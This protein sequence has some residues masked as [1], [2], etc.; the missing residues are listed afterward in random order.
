MTTIKLF[1]TAILFAVASVLSYSQ[2]LPSPKSDGVTI[3][4]TEVSMDKGEIIIDYRILLG[5][6]VLSCRVSATMLLDGSPVKRAEKF[7]GDVG[8]IKKSGAKQISYRIAGKEEQLAGKEISFRLDVSNK[9]VLGNKAL[10]MATISP[11]TP[12][13]YGVM[14]G[15]VKKV[16]GYVRFTSNY[17]FAKADFSA[18]GSGEID[19]G[20]FMWPTGKIK[21]QALQATAGVLIR[22]QKFLYPYVGAGY[23]YNKYLY[24]DLSGDIGYIADLSPRG[25]AAEAGIIFKIGPVSFSAGAGTIMFKTVSLDVGLG[26]MF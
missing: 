18:V 7:F 5:E 20:G 11:F 22:A 8:L 26:V 9:D 19:G 3:G 23:G 6:Q 24:E 17:R 2:G 13:S 15:F 25:A 16:G 1:L 12:S 21:V 10:V 14:A 4:E